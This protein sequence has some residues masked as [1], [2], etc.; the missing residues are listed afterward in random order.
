MR[1]KKSPCHN[2]DF[3]RSVKISDYLNVAHSKR[4]DQ[5]NWES[6]GAPF[7]LKQ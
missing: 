7:H 1:L 2:Q 4:G 6:C 3:G 5:A